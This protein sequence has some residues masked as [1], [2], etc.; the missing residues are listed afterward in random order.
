MK[1]SFSNICR[2]KPARVLKVHEKPI[3]H[4]VLSAMKI[5]LYISF[6]LFEVVIS[7]LRHNKKNW[8]Y[9]LSYTSF[10][11]LHNEM[12][13]ILGSIYSQRIVVNA[14]WLYNLLKSLMQ[15]DLMLTMVENLKITLDKL[16][17][18]LILYIFYEFFTFVN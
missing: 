13:Y 15:I 6:N 5:I 8:L 16:C 7:E 10:R 11:F 12:Y 4:H 17:F 1:N 2:F 3:Y 9:L 18:V 14:R